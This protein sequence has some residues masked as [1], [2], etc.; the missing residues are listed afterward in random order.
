MEGITKDGLICVFDILGYKNFAKN[1]KIFDC[2]QGIKNIIEKLPNNVNDNIIKIFET[3]KKEDKPISNIV[4]EAIIQLLNLKFQHITISDTIIL[5]FDF[6][7]LEDIDLDAFTMM[8]LLY[9]MFFQEISFEKGFPMRG[10]IDIGSFYLNKNIF[11]GETIINCFTESE[12]INFSGVVLTDNSL[13]T[14]E[15]RNTPAVNLF[16]E[17]FIVKKYLVPMNNNTEDYKNLIKWTI[18]RG[19]NIITDLRQ[20]IFEA[21]HAH[22]KEVN[23]SVMEKIKNTEKII[24]YFN[25]KK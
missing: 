21:F 14:L 3:A 1:N 20:T 11:A 5:A 8:S 17:H 16:M 13:K 9:I 2:A 18:K 19:N 25:I 22:N 24:R 12:R 6:T 10:C 15:N 7:E 23:L 4:K